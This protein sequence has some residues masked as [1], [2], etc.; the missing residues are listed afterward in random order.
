MSQQKRSYNSMKLSLG[1]RN[2]STELRRTLKQLEREE[3]YVKKS[4]NIDIRVMK[5]RYKCFMPVP[6]EDQKTELLFRS[7][8]QVNRE[9]RAIVQVY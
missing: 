8:R 4:I 3:K 6:E 7:I 9:N 2:E 5:T 1:N